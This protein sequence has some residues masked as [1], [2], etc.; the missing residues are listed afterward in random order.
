MPS[1]EMADDELGDNLA[2]KIALYRYR[3]ALCRAVIRQMALLTHQRSEI[4]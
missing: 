4:T 1:V 3:V 2:E